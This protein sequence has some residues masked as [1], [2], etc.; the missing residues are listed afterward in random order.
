MSTSNL[1]STVRRPAFLMLSTL[2]FLAASNAQASC[3]SS[4]C[5]VNT[6]WSVQGAW[7]ERGTRVDLRFE[8]VNQNRLMSG[9]DKVTP[10][11]ANEVELETISR[12]WVFNLDHAFHDN[13]G[14]SLALPFLD[15]SHVHTESAERVNWTYRQIGDARAALRYQSDIQESANGKNAVM[16]ATLGF[17]LA[18]AKTNIANNT[19]TPAERSLQPGSGTTDLI[20]S[21]YYR[22]VLPDLASTWFVQLNTEIPLNEKDGYQ[23]GATVGVDLGLRTEWKFGISPMLQLNFQHKK[24]D[25]GIQAEPDNSG[26]RSL[27]ISPGLSYR[28]NARSHLYGFAQLPVYQYVNGVQLAPKWAFTLGLQSSF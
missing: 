22:R 6:D 23:P 27:S 26:G 24:R 9:A 7:L 19:G 12:R 1:C 4:F 8:Q 21:A 28:I 2:A 18:T 13:W 25:S 15:R 17:K 16:G 5:L 3:G 14:V 11:N 10:S 20:G